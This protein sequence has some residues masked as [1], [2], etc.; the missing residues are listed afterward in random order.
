MSSALVIPPL[1]LVLLLHVLLQPVNIMITQSEPS[2]IFMVVGCF[3]K[4]KAA[5]STNSS[6]L[7][8]CASE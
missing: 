1:I 2:N 6:S 4:I 5:D 7:R 3:V 8:G